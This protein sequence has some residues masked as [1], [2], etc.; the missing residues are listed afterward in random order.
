[1]PALRLDTDWSGTFGPDFFKAGPETREILLDVIPDDFSWE[2]SRVM[3][4]GCGVGR[5]L[6]HFREEAEVAE[7]WGV[8]VEPSVL[9]PFEESL[10][11]PMHAQLSDRD[12]PLP[13]DDGSFDLI[14]AVS[15]W[16]HL[17]DNALSWLA[18]MHRLLK[19]GGILIPTYIGETHSEL[20]AGEEWEEDRIGMNVLRHYQGWDQG[21]PM[22]LI[23]DWWLR[24]HWGR[25]F[26]V[27]RIE[28]G[29]H[30]MNWPVLRK[31]D[32]RITAED[33]ARPGE[34]PRELVA[35]RHNLRQVQRELEMAL[36]EGEEHTEAERRRYEGSL[37]W[38][39]TKSL[40]AARQRFRRRSSGGGS[41]PSA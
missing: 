16:T 27:L 32:V 29:R 7:I 14:W 22:V 15:V 26:D 40:R 1:L 12:P 33:L 11:P 5:T 35:L 19:P 36:R 41:A 38:R 8:D 30:S 24:E 21:G 28:H 2:G 34:D 17:A 25:A 37:S 31:R 3:D 23:S 4:F 10:C 13:F 20:L 9:R 6:V 39:A 18:E